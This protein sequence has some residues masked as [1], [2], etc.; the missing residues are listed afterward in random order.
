M[1][2]YLGFTISEQK[3]AKSR[4]RRSFLSCTQ[5]GRALRQVAGARLREARLA[6]DTLSAHGLA[7]LIGVSEETIL[8]A[9]RSNADPCLT[10]V[11]AL[12]EATGQSMGWLLGADVWRLEKAK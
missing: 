4:L 3:A 9:E 12:A 6:C 5:E 1:T 10:H 11:Y 8:A 2:K 7:T